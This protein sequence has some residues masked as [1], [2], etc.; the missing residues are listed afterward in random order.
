MPSRPASSIRSRTRRL[1]LLGVGLT[2]V[3]SGVARSTLPGPKALGDDSP[4]T[5]G[6]VLRVR[7]AGVLGRVA[8]QPEV[9][10][11]SALRASE[12]L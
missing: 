9:A 10:R 6:L 8:A 2:M 1:A 12:G 11:V 5:V 3:A 4:L 7:A